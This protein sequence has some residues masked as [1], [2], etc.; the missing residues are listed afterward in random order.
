MRKSSPSPSFPLL[1]LPLV[2]VDCPSHF[3][4]ANSPCVRSCN[5]VFICLVSPFYTYIICAALASFLSFV[6]VV[7]IVIIEHRTCAHRELFSIIRNYG[8][9]FNARM[10][11]AYLLFGHVYFVYAIYCV[12]FSSFFSHSSVVCLSLN[13]CYCCCIFPCLFFFSLLFI[14]WEVLT[15]CNSHSSFLLSH[16]HIHRSTCISKTEIETVSH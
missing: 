12:M 2:I 3:Y 16:S 6:V 5:W 4:F 1:R 7:V 9:N 15:F 10:Y 11:V 13:V 8:H 14:L